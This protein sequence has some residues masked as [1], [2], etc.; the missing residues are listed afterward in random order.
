M[1]DLMLFFRLEPIEFEDMFNEKKK[2]R[3]GE[4]RE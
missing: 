2:K 3:R 4:R 1:K